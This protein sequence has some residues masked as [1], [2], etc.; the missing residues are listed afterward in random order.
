MSGNDIDKIETVDNL[1]A[2]NFQLMDEIEK[3]EARI[4]ELESSLSSDV[5]VTLE[6]KK[7]KELE[8]LKLS[9]VN[10]VLQVQ[11]NKEKGRAAN[12]EERV[13]MMTRNNEKKDIDPNVAHLISKNS[14]SS[15]DKSPKE[16]AQTNDSET[17]KELQKQISTQTLALKKLR[18]QN[19]SLKSDIS[20]A[21]TVLQKEVS[22]DPELIDNILNGNTSTEGWKGREQKIMLLKNQLK[23]ARKQIEM[24]QKGLSGEAPIP[25]SSSPNL[26]EN[27]GFGSP[28]IQDSN[29]NSELSNSANSKRKGD[30]FDE[31]HQEKLDEMDKHKK[32]TIDNLKEENINLKIQIQNLESKTESFKARAVTLQ[33]ANEETQLKMD[34]LFSKTVTDDKLIEA[35]KKELQN[36]DS[37]IRDLKIELDKKKSQVEQEADLMEKTISKMMKKPE[38][39]TTTKSSSSTTSAGLEEQQIQELKLRY[40]ALGVRVQNLQE[41]NNELK[42]R[43]SLRSS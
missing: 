21:R 10:R 35:F 17:I 33:R 37:S 38:F 42:I 27:L 3:K 24:L 2:V 43:L 13:E 19:T 30:Y 29:N 28:N 16:G 1:K 9:K 11:L 7:M 26:T 40:N 4:K 34:R 12:L 8:I 18:E 25:S 39:S 15:K 6:E 14:S 23:E 36:K 22:D 41:E 32:V 20:R 5:M 31:K